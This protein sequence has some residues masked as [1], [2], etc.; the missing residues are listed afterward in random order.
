MHS[1]IDIQE[2]YL[3]AYHQE[4]DPIL[5]SYSYSKRMIAHEDRFAEYEQAYDSGMVF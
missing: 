4:I 2:K 5:S 1:C 3:S